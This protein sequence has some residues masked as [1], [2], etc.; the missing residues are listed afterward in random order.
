MPTDTCAWPMGQNQT[1]DFT[2]YGTNTSWNDKAGL[3]IFAYKSNQSWYAVYVGQTDSFQNR[4]TNHDRWDEGAQLGATHIHARTVGT[5]A[6]R[7]RLE[8]ALIGHLQPTL[9]EQ[10]R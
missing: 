8:A 10:L 3:Y 1:L 9:N 4:L 5:Q 6:D 7:D 2:I